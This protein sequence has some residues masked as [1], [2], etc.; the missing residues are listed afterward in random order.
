[1]AIILMWNCCMFRFLDGLHHFDVAIVPHLQKIF[2]GTYAQTLLISG[3]GKGGGKHIG[4]V[5]V[6]SFYFTGLRFSS[7]SFSPFSDN[8]QR[9]A[10]TH[11]RRIRPGLIPVLLCL[12]MSSAVCGPQGAFYFSSA[13]VQDE[14][15]FPHPSHHMTQPL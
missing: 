6:L 3:T 9:V 4:N 11:R 15:T 1:M 2:L 7:T 13:A 5:M 12:P 10:G 14:S 8:L